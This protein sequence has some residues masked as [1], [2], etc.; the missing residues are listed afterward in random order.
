[1]ELKLTVYDNTNRSLSKRIALPCT[2]GRS[3]KASF[4]IPDPLVSRRH[5]EIFADD[6]R[7]MLKD[8]DSLNGTFL[9]GRR[10]VTVM[11]LHIGDTFTIGDFRFCISELT[12]QDRK[13]LDLASPR[14]ISGYDSAPTIPVTPDVR[15]QNFNNT[16]PDQNIMN[17]PDDGELQLIDDDDLQIVDNMR[18]KK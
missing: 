17:N 9:Q 1:M 3:R 14:V 2:I 13:D 16:S 4:P 8:L 11:P 7:V 5:C 15:A 18:F 6:N 12:E 10:I